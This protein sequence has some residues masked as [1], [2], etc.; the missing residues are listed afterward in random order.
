MKENFLNKM[1]ELNIVEMLR[2][3]GKYVIN[4]Y[5]NEI[6]IISHNY[7]EEKVLRVLPE[8][9]IVKN[10]FNPKFNTKNK[11][12]TLNLRTSSFNKKSFKLILKK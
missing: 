1:I 4:I 5:N 9:S 7:E 6:D 11:N 10:N 2:D 12:D 8:K 3:I